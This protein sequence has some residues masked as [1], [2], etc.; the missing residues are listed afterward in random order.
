MCN[1]KWVYQASDYKK[2]HIRGVCYYNFKRIDTYYC[3][4]CCEV[5]EKVTKDE[6]RNYFKYDNESLPYWW[7][8]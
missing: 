3:E 5:K 4:K 8:K 2:T 6:Y 1:H 7:K